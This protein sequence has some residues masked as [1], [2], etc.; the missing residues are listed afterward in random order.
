M[1]FEEFINR[2]SP[3]LKGITHKLNGRFTF[4]DE[5]DLYQE[6]LV[7]LW[8]DCKDGRLVD[9]NDSY[10]LQGCYYHL[11][12]YIRKTQDKACLISVH[13]LVSEEGDLELEGILSLEDPNSYFDDINSKILI[14]EI[15]NDGLTKR[16]KEVFSLCLKGL[17]TRQIGTILGISHVR[18]VKLRSKIKDKCKKYRDDC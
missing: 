13:T 12:N 11:K 17:T 4:F 7:H 5:D 3:K 18:V 6:A 10:I 2:I 14:E 9:K 8:I 1:H 15:L 16:E